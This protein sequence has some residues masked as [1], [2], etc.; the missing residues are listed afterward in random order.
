M[1]QFTIPRLEDFEGTIS[2]LIKLLAELQTGQGMQ[3]HD[4]A[5]HLWPVYATAAGSVQALGD[6]AAEGSAESLSRSDHKHTIPQ[7]YQ[8]TKTWD[9]AASTW[10]LA[11]TPSPAIVSLFLDG[12]KMTPTTDYTL[13]TATIQM[14]D[15]ANWIPPLNS[16]SV[17]EY[18]A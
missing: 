15:G 11:H 18:F 9:G 16:V 5:Y 4:Q 12:R 6:S 10:V 13:S 3:P 2:Y 14:K 17:C 8:E 1:P 7:W